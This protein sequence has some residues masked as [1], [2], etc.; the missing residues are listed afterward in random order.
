MSFYLSLFSGVEHWMKENQ[1]CRLI[2]LILIAALIV[3]PVSSASAPATG[4]ELSDKT[5]LFSPQENIVAFD[6]DAQKRFESPE[7][8]TEVSGLGISPELAGITPYWIYLAAGKKEQRALIDFI[9]KSEVPEKKKTEWIRFLQETWKKYPLKFEKKGSTATLGL[10][11]PVKEY[12]LT[13]QEAVTFAE[14]DSIITADMEKTARDKVGIRWA[15]DQHHAFMETAFIN[16]AYIVAEELKALSIGSSDD[17]DDW[18]SDDPIG[19][20]AHSIN[21]GY[22]ITQYTP[23]VEGLGL[24]PQNTGTYA[25][26]AKAKYLLHDYNGAFTDLGYSSHF[27]TDLGQPYHTPNLILGVWPNYD[28]PFSTESKIVRYKTL[29]D[30]YEGFV[31]SYWSQP[32]PNGRNFRDY[33]NSATGATIIVDPTTSAK[34]HAVASNGVSVP[35][36]YLCSWHYLFN[37]NYEFQ[38]NAAIVALTGERVTATTQNTRGLVRFVTGEQ[39]P[40]LTIMASAGEHGNISP[41]GSISVNYGDSQSFTITPESGYTIDQILVDNSPVT[42]QNPYPFENVQADHTIAVSFKPSA[43]PTTTWN[44][45]TDGWGDWQHTWSVSGAQVG[46]NSEYGPVMVGDHGEHGTNTNLLAGSTESSVWRTFT[47]TTGGSGWNTITFTGVMTASDVPN[48]RWMTVD[49]NGNQVFG[50]TAA[51]NPPGNGVPFEITQSFPSA[52]TAT[53][54]ISNGQNPAWGPRFAMSYHS[55][56]LSHDGTT[57]ALKAADVPFVIP[58]GKGLVTNATVK[59]E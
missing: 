17:P 56:T 59:T 49:V 18:Y 34:Y 31:A 20:L 6:Q 9:R 2:G 7:A 40:T 57:T 4:T 36:Y 5:A 53:V 47:D 46:P 15:F 35:L 45:A 41:A 37:R 22:L 44:W 14:I 1:H 58:D 55:I 16:E 39:V 54:R 42:Q 19:I 25:L 43:S 28:D 29:H 48:G 50:G 8:L 52:S 10:L 13:R 32:L 12:T 51:Q 3:M 38:N 23:A 30:Q 27:I 11:K 26:S 21:H 33:A 24:A